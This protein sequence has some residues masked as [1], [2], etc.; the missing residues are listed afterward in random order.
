MADSLAPVELRADRAGAGGPASERR[1]RCA[2][3]VLRKI[4]RRCSALLFVV[5]FNFFLFR[6]LPGDPAKS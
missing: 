2:G 3:Y 5:V 6:V 4:A 1:A